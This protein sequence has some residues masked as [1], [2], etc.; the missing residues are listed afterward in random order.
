MVVSLLLLA[1]LLQAPD[2]GALIITLG[3]DTIGVERYTL[4]ASRGEPARQFVRA[5][6]RARE[7][8]YRTLGL[9]EV[10]DQPLS[11]LRR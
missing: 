5:D 10:F 8:E 6:L 2:S 11:F 3:E 4:H 7:D 1:R 9:S